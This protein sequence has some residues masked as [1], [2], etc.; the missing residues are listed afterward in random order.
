MATSPQLWSELL[1]T[2]HKDLPLTTQ[3]HKLLLQERSALENRDYDNIKTLLADKN[4]LVENL[5]QHAHTRMHALQAAGLADET[6]TLNAA[7]QESPIVAKAWRQLAQQ[8]DECQHLNAVNER[9]LQRTRLV[10]NQTLDLLRGAN[11]Q[12]RLYDPKGMANNN[13]TGRSITS[14]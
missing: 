3:L 10:V 13:S 9:I 8:W 4:S 12:N 1:A 2:F 6:A 11:Q 5:K 14:A 7:E